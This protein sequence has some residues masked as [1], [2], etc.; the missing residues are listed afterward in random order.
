LDS[1]VLLYKHGRQNVRNPQKQKNEGSAVI[2]R[3][4]SLIMKGL[5]NEENNDEKKNKRKMATVLQ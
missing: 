4:L 1:V 2:P 3:F 5:K